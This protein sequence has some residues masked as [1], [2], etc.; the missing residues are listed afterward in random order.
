[1]PEELAPWFPGVSHEVLLWSSDFESRPR[2]LD[3]PQWTRRPRVLLSLSEHLQQ[4]VDSQG[5]LIPDARH[6]PGQDRVAAQDLEGVGHLPRYH[7][8]DL[9]LR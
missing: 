7:P 9:R 6:D 5:I 3:S 8:C 1:M 2:H 4:L